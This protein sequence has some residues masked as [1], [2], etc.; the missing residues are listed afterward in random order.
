MSENKFLCAVAFACIYKAP[1]WKDWD[2]ACAYN[3]MCNKFA[4]HYLLVNEYIP[5]FLIS[6][7]KMLLKVSVNVLIRHDN[8]VE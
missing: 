8:G 2:K 1:T 7:F 5:S 4:V 3:T 6:F